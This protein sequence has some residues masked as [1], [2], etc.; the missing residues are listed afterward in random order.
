MKDIRTKPDLTDEGGVALI[1]VIILTMVLMVMAATM[2]FEATRENNI[3]VADK[4]GG[5]AFSYSEGGI[6]TVL[7]ILNYAVTESQLTQQRADQSPDR[8]GYLMD[9]TVSCRQDP[10]AGG[11]HSGLQ[12]NIGG[13]NFLVFVDEVDQNGNHCTNCGVNLGTTDPAFL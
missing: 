12:M 7:D 13:S 4:A 2:Y 6:E 3:S 10:T 11:C 9:P 1:T 5:Q 8:H